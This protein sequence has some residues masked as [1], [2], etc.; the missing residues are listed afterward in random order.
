MALAPDDPDIL[1]AKGA[2][3]IELPR[4]LGGDAEQGRALLR[5]AVAKDPHDKAAQRYLSRA[6][7]G[8]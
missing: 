3:L 5:A 4:Y 6:D 2:F 8:Y 7:T 1:T